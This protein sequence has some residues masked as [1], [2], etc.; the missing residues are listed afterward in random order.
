MVIS[1]IRHRYIEILM[2]GGTIGF[3]AHLLSGQS[4][5]VMCLDVAM[6]VFLCTM[7]WLRRRSD[8]ASA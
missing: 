1:Y 5:L 6:L 7:L 4:R 3:A 8:N 2:V